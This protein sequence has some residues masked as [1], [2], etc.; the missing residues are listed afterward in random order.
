MAIRRRMTG[1]ALI[2][3]ATL[4]MPLHGVAAGD[5]EGARAALSRGLKALDGGDPRTARVEFMNALKADPDW[6]DARVAQARALVLIGDGVGA[7]GEVERAR[8]LGLPPGATR[9]LMAHARLL[10]GEPDDALKE[11]QAR[12]VPAGQRAYALRIAGRALAMLGRTAQAGQAF[13]RALTLRPRDA[14]TWIDIGRFR[15]ANGDQAG[16]IAAADTAVGLA[17]RSAEAV[18]LRA[19]LIRDQYGL[20]AAVPWFDRALAIDPNDMPTLDAYAATLADMG[21]ARRMLAMTRRMLA[22]EPGNP[23]AFFMQAVMAARAG[24]H[25]LARAMLGR[26][27]GRLDRSPATMLLRGA[28]Y[29][30]GGSPGLAVDPLGALG[31]MQPDNQ[32][33]RVLLG[34]ALFD[35]GRF[36]EAAATLAPLVE[37]TDADSYA[38]TLA[39]RAREAMGQRPAAEALLDRASMPETGAEPEPEREEA[40]ALPGG[41]TPGALAGAAN[42]DPAAAAPNIAY[43]RALIASGQ[44]EPA[45]TRAQWLRDANRGA[46][47]AY[48]VL[49]DTLMAAGRPAD[50]AQAY[51]KAANL[52]FSQGTALRLVAAWRQAGQAD[53]AVRVLGLY[54]GQNPADVPAARIA[55]S[56]W[57]EVKNWDAAVALLEPLRTR[58]GDNDALLMADLAWAWLGKGDTARARAYAAHAYRLQPANPVAA[59]V[60]G[61]VL[62]RTG[63]EARNAVDLLE[64]AVAVAPG[65]PL[66]ARHLRAAYAKTG[67]APGR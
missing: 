31:R 51:E 11:A 40:G 6:A 17:P 29:I 37:R 3:A 59:D 55:A 64:K 47:A 45:V 42:A 16:A 54:L 12:D 26:T 39:A 15:I 56:A 20:V 27:G 1:I 41:G 62:L 8:A 50:A 35:D 52:H 61:W 25:K 14:A 53:R 32:K 66:L 58:L 49:G 65:H 38:L 21:Q 7:Q 48:V 57:G 4:L 22:L 43:I 33:V 9:V 46:P 5:R 60:Y 30:E 67:L 44:M 19:M 36:A 13:D 63:G 34:R 23:R 2:G 24:D 28:L 18:T 10:Q